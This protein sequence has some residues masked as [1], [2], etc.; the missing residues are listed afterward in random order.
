[1]LDLDKWQEI[2]ETVRKNKLRTL[3][4]GFSVAWGI[5]MLIVLL[6]SGQG[7]RNGIAYQF[8]DDAINSLWIYPGQ[9]S[10]PY[11]GLQPGRS[12]Q[13]TNEDH[14]E[15]S[16]AINGVEHSTSRFYISG[17]V[18]VRRGRETGA[19]SVRCVHPGHR[20]VENTILTEGR[21]INERDVDEY[22][23]S[24]VIGTRVKAALFGEADAIG[25]YIEVNGVAFRVV[26]VF[27]D[28]GGEGEQEQ[29][30]L[31]ISTAQR[32]FGGANRVA[33][34]ML[35]TEDA[36]LE[37]SQAMV[38]EVTKRLARRHAFAPDDPRAVFINNNTENFQR[39]VQLMAGIRAFIWVIGLGTILAGVVGVSNIMMITVRERTKEIGVRKALGATPG[40]IIGLILQESIFITAVAGYVGLVLGVFTLELV[41]AN[42]QGADF[43]RNPE[44]N[45][46]VAIWATVVLV[47]AG[48]LAGL[49]P[50]RRAAAIRPIEALRDE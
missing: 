19:F 42:I 12:V 23:K 1:M 49:V 30:Y 48:T 46:P 29:V 13:F 25:E 47:V 7:L 37:R 43:F 16:G 39:F 20:Y 2:F 24:A 22:R 40:S 36:N 17:S 28:E 31:P 41:A 32:A 18:N 5:F 15:L 4:T 26:G 44:V 11:R 8:R 14:D 21:F 45:L 10:V 50:A 33:Q 3:L 27:T 34:I 6:G 38:G 9:T 35:T